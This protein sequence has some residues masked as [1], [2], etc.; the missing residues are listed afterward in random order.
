MAGKKG[1]GGKP[2]SRSRTKPNGTGGQGDDF[3][4]DQPRGQIGDNSK[5]RQEAIKAT[6]ERIYARDK[7]IDDLMTKYITPL[8]EEN[9]KDKSALRKNFDISTKLFT[10]DYSLYRIQRKARETNDD[11]TT[12]TMKELYDSTPIGEGLDM[13]EVLKRADE[14][15]AAALAKKNQAQNTELAA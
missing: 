15:R 2:N 8:R 7:K 12:A 5:N 9:S 11:I 14:T 10:A 13:F 3:Q 6:K 4:E 1:G